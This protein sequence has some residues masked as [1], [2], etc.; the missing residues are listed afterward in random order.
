MGSLCFLSYL[1]THSPYQVVLENCSGR[2]IIQFETEDLR[3][4]PPNKHN[5]F[6]IS[7]HLLC[8][9]IAQLKNKRVDILQLG[10]RFVHMCTSCL[11]VN[12]DVP[13]SLK[14]CLRKD[15]YV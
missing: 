11:R 13:S 3:S 10:K 5:D 12:E 8:Q 2:Q 9:E 1:E 15:Y 4:F 7:F 6:V 14:L